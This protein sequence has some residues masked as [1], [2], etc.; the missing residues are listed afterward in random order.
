MNVDVEADGFAVSDETLEDFLILRGD[1]D[2]RNVVIGVE[3]ERAGMREVHAL[4]FSAALSADDGDS[5]GIMGFFQEG[6][7]LGEGGHAVFGARALLHGHEDFA[8]P[9]GGIL[10]F[11]LCEIV[12][13]DGDN[14]GVDAAGGS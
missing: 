5:A 14:V 13:V 12:N 2:D 8:A 10:L 3:A 11:F 1:A 6:A 7:E 9:V 4:G